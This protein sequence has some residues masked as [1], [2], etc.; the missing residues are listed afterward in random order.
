MKK[1]EINYSELLN[2]ISDELN[3]SGA[4]IRLERIIAEHLSNAGANLSNVAL[5]NIFDLVV[6][7]TEEQMLDILQEQINNS[8]LNNDGNNNKY[9]IT[10]NI[11]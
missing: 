5:S 8:Y 10:Y 11:N 7:E 1:I 9:E 6:V 3:E 2:A 4:Y